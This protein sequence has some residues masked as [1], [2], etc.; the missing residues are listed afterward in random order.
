DDLSARDRVRG[1]VHVHG[2][3]GQPVVGRADHGVGAVV[4]VGLGSARGRAAGDRAGTMERL[5]AA[6]SSNRQGGSYGVVLAPDGAEG[7]GLAGLLECFRLV[8]VLAVA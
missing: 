7:P 8:G 1:G 2:E 5:V 3:R 6:V 4:L